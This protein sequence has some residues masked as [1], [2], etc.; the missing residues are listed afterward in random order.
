M[1]VQYKS[2][3][4]RFV[5]GLV[6]R[7][8]DLSLEDSHEFGQR[9][10]S[11]ECFDLFGNFYPEIIQLAPRVVETPRFHHDPLGVSLHL[12]V[13]RLLLENR[14]QSVVVGRTPDGVNHRKGQL[15]L[16][17]VFAKTLGLHVFFVDEV[18]EIV[19]YLEIRT[20][21]VD[22]RCIIRSLV[23]GAKG[24]H[25]AQGQPKEPPGFVSNHVDVFL[26]G[27]TAAVFSPQ[28]VAALAPVQV[29]QLPHKNVHRLRVVQGVALFQGKKVGVIRRVDGGRHAENSVGD[30]DAPAQLR[31]VLDV[32]DHKRGI[33][34][35]SDDVLNGIEDAG[36]PVDVEPQLEAIDHLAP[37]VFPR[38]RIDVAEGF[39]KG[40]I[41]LVER[42]RRRRRGHCVFGIVS[43]ESGTP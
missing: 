8:S 7:R 36:G 42:K 5:S 17:Q 33:V 2:C 18:Y 16:C 40:G 28:Y 3:L 43:T 38:H 34:E 21:V 39:H 23:G 20:E 35:V 6:D 27:G 37:D 30:G 12:D 32:V 9:G 41:Y 10:V 26:F 14:Q 19:P 25:K 24:L 31:V 11:T 1:F 4:F 22:E 29:Q 13:F 15:A